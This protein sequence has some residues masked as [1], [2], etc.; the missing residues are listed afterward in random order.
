MADSGK[1]KTTLLHQQDPHDATMS[2]DEELDTLY[3]HLDVP[4]RLHVACYLDDGVY[5]L[6]DPDT[7]EVVGYSAI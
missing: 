2:Y 4:A 5:A 6:F 7:M 3:I 1:L